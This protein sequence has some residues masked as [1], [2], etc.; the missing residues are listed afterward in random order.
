M[1]ELKLTSVNDK[2]VFRSL[3]DCHYLPLCHLGRFYLKDE[4]EAKGVVQEAFIKLWDNRQGLNPD[5][6]LQN[7]LFTLV[8]NDCLNI[9]KRR[10]MMLKHHNE[11]RQT[12][13][14]YQ[15]ESLSR[16]SIDYLE[17]KEMNEQ[18]DSAIKN[19]PERYRIVFEMSRL[20][21]M[22]N[23]EI[24]EELQ[25]S[26]KAVEARM[27]KALK[28]LRDELKDYLPLALFFTNLLD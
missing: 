7:F 11:I 17:F 25:L 20:K 19:L 13:I 23:S 26:Q 16:I 3:F 27:T 6:N 21:N 28:I 4:E 10:Q 9:L 18:I 8:K 14:Q 22:K 1:S 15:Y 2:E 5:S 12:E 24:A